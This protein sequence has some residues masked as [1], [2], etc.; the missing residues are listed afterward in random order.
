VNADEAA[1]IERLHSSKDDPSEW[2]EPIAATTRRRLDAV[3]SVRFSPTE[4]ELIREAAGN[5]GVSK[6][7]REAAV[8]QASGISNSP[9]RQRS[10]SIAAAC[11]TVSFSNAGLSASDGMYL[12]I[13]SSRRPASP[14]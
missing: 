4:L 9:T 3:V 1:E 11:P 10:H 8:K 5:R 12:T 2:G 14:R 13:F 7:I 6:F